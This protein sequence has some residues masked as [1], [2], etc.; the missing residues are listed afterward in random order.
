M[1]RGA[2]DG[3]SLGY[4]RARWYYRL[5]GMKGGIESDRVQMGRA[6]G[7]RIWG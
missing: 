5:P 4:A 7:R 2:G 3:E 6:R 1:V